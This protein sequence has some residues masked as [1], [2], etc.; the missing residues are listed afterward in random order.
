MTSAHIRVTQVASPWSRHDALVA[1]ALMAVGGVV[2]FVGW[3][4]V[5]HGVAMDEQIV[6]LNVA[7]IG[8]I[9][10]GA[11]QAW[12][13]LRGRRTIRSRRSA[14]LAVYRSRPVARPER[15]V[16]VDGFV[17]GPRFFHR[18]DCA[19]TSGRSWVLAARAE[20]EQAG[21]TPCGVCLS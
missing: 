6:P 12:F 10:V 16:A 15:A 14:L 19:M 21:R 2:W 9:L 3:W 1:C 20:Q 7:V 17:G 13:F 8:L 5:A 18:P 4:Q 11:G